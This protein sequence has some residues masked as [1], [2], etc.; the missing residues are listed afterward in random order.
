MF[1]PIKEIESREVMLRN[2][3]DRLKHQP[4]DRQLLVEAGYLVVHISRIATELYFRDRTEVEDVAPGIEV[5]ELG[6][7]DHKRVRQHVAETLDALNRLLREILCDE[8]IFDQDDPLCRLAVSLKQRLPD[9]GQ[10]DWYEIAHSAI[11][12]SYALLG[13]HEYG[14]LFAFWQ[15]STLG[16][17]RLNWRD[18]RE[19]NTLL[20]T[21]TRQLDRSR[22][23]AAANRYKL[24]GVEYL[25]AGCHG[26]IAKAGYRAFA[27]SEGEDMVARSVANEEMDFLR[28]LRTDV[29][30]LLEFPTMIA[31]ASACH[32]D[33]L[34][35]PD[36]PFMGSQAEE[37]LE[38]LKE[39]E[40]CKKL[41]HRVA[42][43]AKKMATPEPFASH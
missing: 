30:C 8:M 16:Y 26:N 37:L 10:V 13:N 27:E 35:S 33:E 25:E 36:P 9:S 41:V 39:I 34:W 31:M 23:N 22:A 3:V 19:L 11:D 1:E 42:N 14:G 38:R 17:E 6:D 12:A 28:E 43:W 40:P 5:Y 20:L 32:E 18:Q 24:P 4:S 2:Y 7:P 29:T 15:L 21:K